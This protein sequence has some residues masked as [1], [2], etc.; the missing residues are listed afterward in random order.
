MLHYFLTKLVL[1]HEGVHRDRVFCPNRGTT[2]QAGLS[3]FVFELHI[4]ISPVFNSKC[5][6]AKHKFSTF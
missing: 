1:Q 4:N 6:D 2:G 5:F 3:I